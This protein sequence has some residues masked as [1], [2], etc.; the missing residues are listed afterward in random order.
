MKIKILSKNK[1]K[2]SNQDQSYFLS[3]SKTLEELIF[4]A[5]ISLKNEPF[6]T[7]YDKNQLGEIDKRLLD[8]AIE[9]LFDDIVL[10]MET[11]S[12]SLTKDIEHCTLIFSYN[13]G[14]DPVNIPISFPDYLSLVKS[15]NIIKQLS[16]SINCVCLYTDGRI[17]LCSDDKTIKV[18]NKHNYSCELNIKGHTSKV[19][20]IS[21]LNSGNLISSSSDFTMRVWEI[22]YKTY[23]CIKIITGHSYIVYKA[24]QISDNRIC[25]CS[26][27]ETIKIWSDSDF[28]CLYTI[29][30]KNFPLRS[31]IELSNQKYIVSGSSEYDETLRFW[32]TS[33][34]ELEKSIED[35]RCCWNN[36]LVEISDKFLV[37]GGYNK[38]VIVNYLTF[39]K[40]REI[41]IENEENI[42]SIV[43][44]NGK[45]NVVILSTAKGH[46]VSVNISTH[47][48][49][50]VK[51]NAHKDYIYG[52]FLMSDNTLI[53]CSSDKL[54]KIW[55]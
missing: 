18:F 37:V 2:I 23:K 19:Y 8:Y 51:E 52:L 17:V 39:L 34:Y 14:D 21:L 42:F 48:M 11:E 35:C 49:I 46:L 55:K 50:S 6:M 7:K 32:N 26:I 53:S 5:Q 41:K 38:I 36:S 22:K 29:N 54:L 10:I 20:Y 13:L 47:N 30:V 28:S 27:D 1:Y 9:E 40:E 45:N 15:S 33:T 43:K 12:F 31:V 3:L 25:S 24:I 16:D 44:L 4:S